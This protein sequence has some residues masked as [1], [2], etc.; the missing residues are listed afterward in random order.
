M[1]GAMATSATEELRAVDK[2]ALYRCI[3]QAKRLRFITLAVAETAKFMI[4]F[5]PAGADTPISPVRV[6]RI[7]S[8][9][10]I[11]ARTVHRHTQKLITVGIAINRTLDGGHR[12]CFRSIDGITD[13]AGIDFTPLLERANH[14]KSACEALD[15]QEQQKIRLRAEISMLRRSIRAYT[16]SLIDDQ[17]DI[18]ERFAAL[19]R[20]V[21]HMSLE[22]LLDLFDAVKGLFDDISSRFGSDKKS[23]Q[24][25]ISDLPITISKNSS[26]LSNRDTPIN[27]AEKRNS[28]ERDTAPELSQSVQDEL[29]EFQNLL[30]P[31]LLYRLSPEDWQSDLDDFSSDPGWTELDF[32][33]EARAAALG[34]W[35]AK[36]RELR[37]ALGAKTLI[38]LAI[39][40]DHHGPNGTQHIKKPVGWMLAM[41]RRIEAGDAHLTRSLFGLMEAKNV[42]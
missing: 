17:K 3:D 32:V 23:D 8:E 28:L 13:I 11:D 30:S 4:R 35:P 24:S 37:N 26:V 22:A 40:I 38:F 34:V 7:A 39:M 31:K 5:I 1:Q 2:A 33:A 25:D 21:A 19:P 42:K 29:T 27:N 14:L 41:T 10:G 12:L 15:D 16:E 36:F 18:L 6:N 9:L 20:R